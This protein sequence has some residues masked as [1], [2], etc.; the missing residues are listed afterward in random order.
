M[1]ISGGN[2]IVQPDLVNILAIPYPPAIPGSLKFSIPFKLTKD[3]DISISVVKLI[4]VV[5]SIP[6][7]GEM[8]LCEQLPQIW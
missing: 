7:F 3:F 4:S 2:E 1:K 6:F 8:D 5:R